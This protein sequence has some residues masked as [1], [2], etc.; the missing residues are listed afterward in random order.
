MPRLSL[1]EYARYSHLLYFT[2]YCF[3]WSAAA[4]DV[5]AQEQEIP[6][7]DHRH[8]KIRDA[9]DDVEFPIDQ[10][11]FG[12]SQA[13]GLAFLIVVDFVLDFLR[14]P[15]ILVSVLRYYCFRWLVYLE[16]FFRAL[17]APGLY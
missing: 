1:A 4:V 16:L 11:Y 17:V 14:Q 3:S 10:E 7:T 12:G 2:L 9:V 15:C 5:G 8:V 13:G 6:D